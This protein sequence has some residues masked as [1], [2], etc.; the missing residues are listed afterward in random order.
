MNL[1]FAADAI[2]DQAAGIRRPTRVLTKRWPSVK[3]QKL[4]MGQ[5][6]LAA[7]VENVPAA[8]LGQLSCQ[9]LSIR[10]ALTTRAGAR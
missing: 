2:L 6:K 10:V 7:W 5:L 4:D 8:T 9:G 1:S 3:L